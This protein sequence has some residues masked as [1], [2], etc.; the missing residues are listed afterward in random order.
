M[1]FKLRSHVQALRAVGAGLTSLEDICER[2]IASS[3]EFSARNSLTFTH[4][5]PFVSEPLPVSIK[6]ARTL[7]VSFNKSCF[8]PAQAGAKMLFY[9]NAAGTEVIKVFEQGRR[10]SPFVVRSSQFWFR[11]ACNASKSASARYSITVTPCVPGMVLALWLC[12]FLVAHYVDEV[13]VQ[14][15]YDAVLGAFWESAVPTVQ[16][17]ALADVLARLLR[18]G[19][20]KPG[21]LG[22]KLLAE[23]SALVAEEKGALVSS[24]TQSLAEVA[25]WMRVPV[26]KEPEV[27][28]TVSPNPAILTIKELTEAAKNDDHMK[29]AIQLA[30]ALGE[31]REPVAASSDKPVS[32]AVPVANQAEAASGGEAEA[33]RQDLSGSANGGDDGPTSMAALFGGGGD[34]EMDEEL[35]LA[36]EMS[37]LDSADAPQPAEA[38][39]LAT[40]VVAEHAPAPATPAQAQQPP[41]ESTPQTPA[42]ARPTEDSSEPPLKKAANNSSGD[43]AAE[44]STPVAPVDPISLFG[45]KV[46]AETRDCILLDRYDTKHTTTHDKKH[47]QT[48]TLTRRKHAAARLAAARSPAS[49]PAQVSGPCLAHAAR[50]SCAPARRG[51]RRPQTRVRARFGGSA[52]VRAAGAVEG[53]AYR[54]QPRLLCAAGESAMRRGRPCGGRVAECHHGLARQRGEAAAGAACTLSQRRCVH[55]AAE[56]PRLAGGTRPQRGH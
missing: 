40:A 49:A 4:S 19:K 47:A 32:A 50:Q 41:A 7:V 23:V 28:P 37:K 14:R 22:D 42:A 6:G 46:L 10:L 21:K 33:K 8:L 27:V 35:R 43:D 1:G 36:M 38:A 53:H 25:A 44:P 2:F 52:G 54:S 31:R 48:R 18:T 3:A 45:L 5:D 16:K 34:D 26:Q 24:Y 13:N 11:L 39:A 30:E 55:R 29:I 15:L 9:G 12:E 56:R 51:G 17:R 20:V